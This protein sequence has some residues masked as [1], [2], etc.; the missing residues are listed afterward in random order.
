[1]ARCA[2]LANVGLSVHCP[3]RGHIWK[4]K[5]DRPIVTVAH[6]AEFGTVDSLATFRSCVPDN[7]L[8]PLDHI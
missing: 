7:P 1:M 3:S 6:Y 2:M 5:E 4:T 8:P